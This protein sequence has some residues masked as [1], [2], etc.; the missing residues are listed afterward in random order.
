MN[1]DELR[2]ALLSSPKNGF[3]GL[4]QE[5]RAEMEAYCK[6]YAAFMNACKTEPLPRLRSMASSLPCPVWKSSPGIRST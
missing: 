1:A 5:E 4:S 6:R 2:E 3:V